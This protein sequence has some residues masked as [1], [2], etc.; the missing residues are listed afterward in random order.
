MRYDFDQVV[1][2]PK[3]LSAKYDERVKKF[4]SD[5][6]IPP[7]ERGHGLQD[8]PAHHRR[9]EGPGGGGYARYF[10]SKPARSCVA[11]KELPKGVACEIEAIAVK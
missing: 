10:T 4:G 9:P 11:V 8:R 2:R 7:V 1:D 5:D 6:V 3:N